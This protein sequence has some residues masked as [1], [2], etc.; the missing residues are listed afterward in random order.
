MTGRERLP[1]RRDHET[2]ELDHGGFHFVVGVG[3]FADGRLAEMFFS[4]SRPE[5]PSKAWRGTPLS[6]PS[7]ALQAG[8]APETIRHAL[9]RDANGKPTT[10]LGAALDMIDGGT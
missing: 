5:R 7:L 6:S 9:T 8:V 2:V 10:P 4:T 1:N 3:R